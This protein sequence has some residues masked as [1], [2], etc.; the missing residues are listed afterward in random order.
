MRTVL[1]VG[2]SSCGKIASVTAP[3]ETFFSDL[4]D[5]GIT[6]AEISLHHSQYPL[7][8]RKAFASLADRF[9]IT[10]RSYHLPFS[11]FETNDIS[12]L[13][14]SVRKETL[15]MQSEYLKHAGEMGCRVCVIHPSGEPIENGMREERMKRA[16]ESLSLLAEKAAENGLILA[17]EDLPRTCLGHDS[18]EIR[19]LIAVDD[20]LGVCFDTNHLLTEEPT[21]FIRKI[22]QRIVTT[23]VSDYDRIDERHW[24]PG[25][26]VTDW[27]NLYR[28]LLEVGYDGPWLYELDYETPHT[29][30]RPRKLTAKDF[31]KNADE[32]FSGNAPTRIGTPKH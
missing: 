31:K 9:G 16:E 18:E 12:S 29:L 30:T 26:G 8:D 25:E 3:E 28:T 32:I 10:L 1:P 27:A 23:H 4:S 24:M 22:G 7:I 11:P 14:A 2:L 21:D 13:D 20:R 5:A 6:H 17:V 19:R 15:S